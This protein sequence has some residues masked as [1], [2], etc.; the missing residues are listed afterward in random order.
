MDKIKALVLFTVFIDI[1][2]LGVVIPVLPFYV[3]Q[4]SSSPLAVTALI[5]VYAF[6]SFLSAP[7]IGA[8][9]DRY[10]R[11]PALI[12]SIVST[13]VGWLIFAAGRSLP[14]LY[15]GR[16]IDGLAA[17]N[18]PVAQAAITD[19]AKDD[20][21]RSQALGYVG[22]IFGIGFILGPALG[23]LLGHIAPAMPFWFVGTLSA[24]NAILAF[25]F[26]PETRKVTVEN[27]QR[28]ISLNPFAP[29]MRAV[30][31]VS[32]RPNYIAWGMFG[33]AVATTQSVYALYLNKIFG[34]EEY[35]VGFLFMATGVV[36][37]LNQAVVMRRFWLKYFGEPQLELWTTLVFAFGY[38][39]IAFRSLPLFF[40][41]VVITTF[42]QSILRV[43]MNSQML[44][45]S[46]ASRRGEVMGISSAVVSLSAAI[47][48]IAA[49]WLFV[50]N[51]VYPFLVAAIFL[52]I[53][54]F[55]LLSVKK[56][57]PQ[58]LDASQPLVSEI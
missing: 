40:V 17:G 50:A 29:I 4:F 30:R 11:R 37:A 54:F 44:G 45:K 48:P 27:Q 25:F 58:E 8:L 21:E 14:L 23:G 5:A 46:D 57:L 32:L 35:A 41:A 28:K 26:L 12:G 18:L 38:S 47:A 19:T 2:G 52:V 33:L 24:I 7:L 39:L 31:D 16:I 36:L 3:Q 1:L 34:W 22:A 51:P 43:V 15:L 56:N 6:C 53:G 9:S 55:V 20:K 49:G 10:G 42:G 13:S